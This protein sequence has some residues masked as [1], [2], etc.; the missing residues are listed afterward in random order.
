VNGKEIKGKE[1][2]DK[3]KND[4]A[5]LEK[6]AY[7]LKKRG[8][9]ELVQK[10]ILEDEAKKQGTTIDK[11]MAQL[12]EGKDKEVTKEDIKNFLKA[13][14]I[15]EKKLSKQEKESVPQI[16]KMQRVY[17]ARSKFMADLRSKANVQY[18]IKKP[19]EKP[20]DVGVGNIEPHGNKNAKVKIVEFS[21]F[22]C[23]Y[24]AR[25]RTRVDEIVAKYKDKVAIYFRHFPLES[26]HPQAFKSAEA[27]L[28]AQDQ[29]QFWA[30]HDSLF[31]NQGALAEADLLKRA[32]DLKLDEKAFAECLK[33]GKKAADVRKDLDE[34][35]KVGVNS[36]P[37]FFVNGLPVRGAQPIEVL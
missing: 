21:D 1:V 33:S 29:G 5:E 32:K 12:D 20:M 10:Q 7:E 8:T 35:M 31:D 26:I 27:S 16:V 13:R 14:N 22:Q 36:T 9:D 37:S 28:C 4:L 15:D 18:K 17:E 34:G 3:I 11:L 30:Y 24:C 23:P 2:L 6:N 25:G 19:V